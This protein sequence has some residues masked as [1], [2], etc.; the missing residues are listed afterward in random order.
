VK[1]SH[2]VIFV[3]ESQQ[4]LTSDTLTDH[5]SSSLAHKQACWQHL[6]QYTD[7]FYYLCIR[8]GGYVF[9]G[10]SLL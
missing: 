10:V 4:L 2:P 1:P 7:A 3:T 5:L 6:V 9:I 8:Q